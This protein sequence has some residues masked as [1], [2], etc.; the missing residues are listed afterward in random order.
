[1]MWGYGPGFFGGFGFIFNILFWLLII[2]V[3]LAIFRNSRH[4]MYED[5]HMPP[6]PPPKT[7]LQIVQERYARG[8]IDKKEYEEK[9]KDLS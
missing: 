1:M 6:P 5:R 4:P 8:E 7:P 2:G 9:K 3:V